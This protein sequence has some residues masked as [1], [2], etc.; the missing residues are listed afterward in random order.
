MKKNSTHLFTAFLLFAAL[1]SGDALARVGE[2]V[3]T[4]NKSTIVVET[5][6][7]PQFDL[8]NWID[9]GAETDAFN[10]LGKYTIASPYRGLR[11]IVGRGT[12][13]SIFELTN[14]DFKSEA[15]S[16]N[17]GFVPRDPKSK[18]MLLIGPE[19]MT[20]LFRDLE[21][22]PVINQKYEN[23]AVFKKP[24]KSLKIKMNWQEAKKTWQVF[25]GVDGDEP[26]REI[27]ESI[28]G[29]YF[30]KDLDPTVEML[31]FVRNG[32]VDVDHFEFGMHVKG[33]EYYKKVKPELFKR[34]QIESLQL[35][36]KY[37]DCSIEADAEKNFFGAE[38]QI[39][40]PN[41]VTKLE[42]I[43]VR[44]HGAGGNGKRLAHDLQ[45]QA[46]AEKHRFALM[47]SFMK[48]HTDFG[49]WNDPNKGS[50]AAFLKALDIFAQSTKHAELHSLPWILWGHSAG[51]HWVNLMARAHQQ[52]VIAL[53]SRSGHGIEYTGND[54]VI[55][56]LQMAGEKEV[57]YKKQWCRNLMT[58]GQLRAIA[59]E[60]GVGHACTKSRFLTVAFIE[61][62]LFE[63]KKNNQ[64]PLKR[65][66]GWLGDTKTFETGPYDSFSG[67]KDNAY[68]LVNENFARQWKSFVTK[69]NI[70]DTTAP[71]TP[72]EVTAKADSKGQVTI[73][74]KAKADIESGIKKFNVY[75]NNKIIS[76]VDGQGWNR[77]DEPDPI[78]CV[79]TYVDQ[80][81][82]NT[83][84]KSNSPV[85]RYCVTSVNY[86]DIESQ[87]RSYNVPLKV[88]TK[89]KR[90]IATD[91]IGL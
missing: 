35:F 17:L 15:S 3:D 44:Q 27:P 36:G 85:L 16:I 66:A 80:I 56:N 18:V 19:N 86:C 34:Q 64:K 83:L 39:W 30:T 87:K 20:L 70:S 90:K 45:F 25:Y 14:I 68:W 21:S 40:I 60:P 65:T 59:I 88:I 76:S 33:S 54:L 72:Q 50:G 57:D 84:N 53:I 8:P 9:S 91:S 79:T 23:Q 41:N 78:D 71:E 42:G 11:R 73:R 81:D 5:F 2:K 1:S 69:G 48:A 74:W 47:S 6:T 46:L 29:L 75:R 82:W 55:P 12:F 49:Q 28:K 62:V 26:T 24:P 10:G 43:I 38:F 4:V 77:G 13:E 7:G 63:M 37:F 58:T 32:S 22:D 61:E 89:L 67:D 31:L 51:G 52:R